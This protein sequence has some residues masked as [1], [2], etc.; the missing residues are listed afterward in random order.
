[1]SYHKKK[2]ELLS[3][4]EER[5]LLNEYKKNNCQLSL[6]KLLSSNIRLIYKIIT[7]IIGNKD[8]IDGFEMEDLLQEGTIGLYIAIKKFNM[9]TN[10]KLST[11]STFWIKQRI[12]R[13]LTD[14]KNLIRIPSYVNDKLVKLN[15]EI[16]KSKMNLD[17]VLE[18]DEVFSNNV[19]YNEWQRLKEF[20]H[21]DSLD[22]T[23]L[24]DSDET[25]KDTIKDEELNPE[26]YLII[27][28]TKNKIIN[29][30]VKVLNKKE[31]YIL[32]NR[33]GID[34]VC[35]TLEQIGDE[36]NVTRERIRQIEKNSINKVKKYVEK[37]NIE[38][39]FFL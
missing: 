39:G 24:N 5:F 20:S 37:N 13:F 1:M 9:N 18:D 8:N 38:L 26:D 11:Y 6:E 32:I 14:K 3:Y 12:Q 15:K 23:Y 34:C 17:E 35:K 33:F 19:P 7:N 16:K 25:I 30:L 29:I 28:D 21:I 31:L 2:S 27:N 4:D 22:R 10:L 36:L